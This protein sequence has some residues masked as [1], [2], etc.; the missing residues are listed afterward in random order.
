MYTWG[1][2]VRRVYGYS[3]SPAERRARPL[4]GKM[5]TCH[6]CVIGERPQDGPWYAARH[7]RRCS[8]RH[9]ASGVRTEELTT[10]TTDP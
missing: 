10:G 7:W 8:W 5:V 4:Q 9:Q 2:A 3:H 1:P 6:L